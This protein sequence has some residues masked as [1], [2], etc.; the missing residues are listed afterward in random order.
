MKDPEHIFP[1]RS[2][3]LSIGKDD[4]EVR[5][6]V[7]VNPTCATE[8]EG[9]IDKLISHYPK[10]Y[11]LKRAVAWILKIKEMLLHLSRKRQELNQ[12]NQN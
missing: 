6:T 12:S 11:K 3:Q 2:D 9:P 4:L 10:W 7:T 5:K 8:A 1:V